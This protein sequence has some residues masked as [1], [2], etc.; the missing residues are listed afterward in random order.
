MDTTDVATTASLERVRYFPGQLITPDDMIQD[1]ESQRARQRRHTRLL[2]GWGVVAG[3]GVDHKLD[4]QGHATS[5]VTVGAGCVLSPQGD[6][7]SLD[8]P[9]TLDILAEDL[10]GNTVP[11]GD[12]TDP[13]CATV[14][15]PLPDGRPLYLAVRYAETQTRPVRS[16]GGCGCGCGETACEYSRIRDG[17]AFKVLTELPSSYSPMPGQKG[18]L[19]GVLQCDSGAPHPGQRPLP[20]VP[21]E[22]W[23]ILAT[24]S[25]SNSA[26]GAVDCIEYRRFPAA[27]GSF[28]YQCGGGVAE[29]AAPPQDPPAGQTGA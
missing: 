16:A 18:V 15:P 9:V 20:P 3:A 4:A 23:V 12:G 24:I 11:T 6:E 27:F 29:V 17:Y 21:D 14:R 13:W 25:L 8:V 26:V 10:D 19:D 7:I 28:Y 22:P 2:H 5:L 1:Q